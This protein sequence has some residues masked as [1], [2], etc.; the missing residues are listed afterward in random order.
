MASGNVRVTPVRYADI[1][2]IMTFPEVD[3]IF[4]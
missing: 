3:S 4:R 1:I 2:G